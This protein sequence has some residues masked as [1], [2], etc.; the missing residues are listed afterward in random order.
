MA[1]HSFVGGIHPYDG[2]DIS[3]KRSIKDVFP[4]GDMV[5]PLVQHIGAPAVP[6]VEKGDSVKRGQIIAVAGGFVSSNIYSSVSGT[7]KSIEPRR[8]VTGDMVNSIIIT[9]DEKYD[10]VDYEAVED[11]DTLQ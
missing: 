3:K 10:E 4:T 9:N 11:L 5:Y 1:K 2:K 6:V 7:V 8:V